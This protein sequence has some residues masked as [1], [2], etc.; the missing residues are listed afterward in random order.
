MR[1]SLVIAL[2]ATLSLPAHAQTDT[3]SEPEP[4]AETSAFEI[5]LHRPLMK[6][7]NAPEDLLSPFTT[8]GCSGGMSDGWVVMAKVVPELA[9]EIGSTPPWEP[10]CITHDR[11]YH[12]AGGAKTA[13][14]SALARLQADED[15]RACVLTWADPEATRMNALYNIPESQTQLAYSVLAS[16]MYNAVRV[17]GAPCSL[18]S[19]RWGYG[20]PECSVLD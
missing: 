3:M 20:Y 16:G 14:Q 15:L 9:E 8:D 13:I 19:W 10:C 4:E 11:A 1:S 17:G 7:V 12:N 5:W 18:W 6:L 2:C